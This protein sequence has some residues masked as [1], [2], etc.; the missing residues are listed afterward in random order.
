SFDPA[1]ADY[2]AA[3]VAAR[4]SGDRRAEWQ[5]LLDL[6]F[7]WAGRAYEQTRAYF[8]DAL[9]LAR[10]LDDPPALA[11]SLNRV[12]NWHVNVEQPADGERHHREALTIFERLDDRRGI[13]ETLD[14][15]GLA[16]YMQA[17]LVKAVG[18]L[19]RAIAL[20]RELDDRA[21]LTSALAHR[22]VSVTTYHS[23]TAP[24]PP[25]FARQA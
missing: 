20:F 24:T 8:A 2:E 6:G 16:T 13:A 25:E 23:C 1:R 4:V 14:L 3:L 17:D 11:Q 22:A 12:G 18:Y 15:L 10:Q 5:A 19:D 9:D 7:L 21:G